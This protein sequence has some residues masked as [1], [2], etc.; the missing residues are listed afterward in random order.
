MIGRIIDATITEF[1]NIGG[2]G[3]TDYDELSQL[4]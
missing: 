4:Q 2:G 1:T 3:V